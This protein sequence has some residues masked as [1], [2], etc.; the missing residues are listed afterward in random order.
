M[1]G[2][3]LSSVLES[4]PVAESF[5]LDFQSYTSAIPSTQLDSI[6]LDA[7]GHDGLALDALV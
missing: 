7:I 1:H 2:K 6:R 5:V 4:H 3:M